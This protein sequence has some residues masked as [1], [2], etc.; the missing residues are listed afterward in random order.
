[1]DRNYISLNTQI[2][3]YAITKTVF[4]TKYEFKQSYNVTVLDKLLHVQT[5]LALLKKM[6]IALEQ[7]NFNTETHFQLFTDSVEVFERLFCGRPF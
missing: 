3:V 1:M 6:F 7:S 5:H 4:A 2:L